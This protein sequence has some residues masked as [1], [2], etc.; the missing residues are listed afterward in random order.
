MPAIVASVF[1]V[2][3]TMRRWTV[4]FLVAIIMMMGYIFWDIVS[5]LATQLKA[6]LSE[7]GMAWTATEYGFYAGS[8]SILNIFLL[9]LFFGGIILDKFG[10]RFTGLLAT[11]SMFLGSIINYLAITMIS[12][13]EEVNVWFTMF[14]LIPEHV[15]AQVLVAALGFGLFGMGCDITGITI[16]KIVTKWFTGHELASAMGVQ[17]ALARLGTASAIS[18]SPIIAQH[19]GISAPILAGSAILAIGLFLFIVYCIMD[20]KFDDNS[21]KETKADQE[22]GFH[23]HDILAVL[24]NPG[25]WLIALICVFF[26]SSIRPFMK[27]ATDILVNKYAINS[28]TAGW[29][30]SIIPYGT[31]I[32]TPLFGTIFDKSGKGGILMAIGCGILTLGHIMLTLPTLNATW[33]STLIMLMIGIAF[34][35]V[36]SALWPSIPKLI[37]LKQLGTAYSIIYYIQNLGLMLVPIWVGDVIDRNTSSSAP[38]TTPI[39]CSSLS[40]LELPQP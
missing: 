6:P 35:L 37:P 2:F 30:V 24:R 28:V 8:Y 19:F 40:D 13:L 33:I 21:Q 12:P 18:I 4:L 27:F 3:S 17:V 1:F 11:G 20:K 5:P 31:I 15:K 36:P 7:G 9:M 32:L 14:G 29:V 16:S 25:F 34:S 23:L 22:E 39:L 10:I 26:Y 38:S